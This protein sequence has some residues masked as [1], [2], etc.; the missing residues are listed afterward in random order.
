[1]VLN[2][3][4]E[5]LLVAKSG[6]DR[7]TADQA[8]PRLEVKGRPKVAEKRKGKQWAEGKGSRAGKSGSRTK[9]EVGVAGGVADRKMAIG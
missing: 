7:R 8:M 4:L 1:M 5:I 9:K 6:T 3:H 2:R